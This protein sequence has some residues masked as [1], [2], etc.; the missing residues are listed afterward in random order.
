MGNLAAANNHDLD[1]VEGQIQ[2]LLPIVKGVGRKW[3]IGICPPPSKHTGLLPAGIKDERDA[4]PEGNIEQCLST[5]D[6]K[7]ALIGLEAQIEQCFKEWKKPAIDHASLQ[8]AQV[9]RPN[10]GCLSSRRARQDSTAAMIA[11][12]RR[13]K[14]GISL[15]QICQVLDANHWPLREIYQSAG[16]KNW[17]DAWKDPKFRQRIKRFI[18]AIQPAAAKKKV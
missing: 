1:W 12:V 3:V 15:E 14:P 7:K 11:R 10:T 13:D 4:I 6:T 17:H 8:I 16:F 9:V 5:A 18:S 2:K